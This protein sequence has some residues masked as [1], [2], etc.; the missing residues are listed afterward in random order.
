MKKSGICKIIICFLV[1]LLAA[2]SVLLI[3]LWRKNRA[4]RQEWDFQAD[5]ELSEAFDGALSDGSIEV[6]FQPIVSPGTGE[7]VGAE[8]LSR[9]KKGEEYISP[10]VF[11]S[12]G[13]R[14]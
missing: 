13:T 3:L 11:V 7:V 2:E 8:V 12:A 10:S 6:W 4:S 9:W 14:M 5:T 1:L